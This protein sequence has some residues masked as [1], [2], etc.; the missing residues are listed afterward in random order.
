MQTFMKFCWKFDKKGLRS[1]YAL[2]HNEDSCDDRE[3]RFRAR[4]NLEVIYE[5]RRS[6]A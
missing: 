3:E 5:Q 1:I 6:K 4:I 2:V